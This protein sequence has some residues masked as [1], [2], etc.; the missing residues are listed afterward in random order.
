MIHDSFL[1]VKK[2]NSCGMIPLVRKGVVVAVWD[3]SKSKSRLE[4]T[5]RSKRLCVGDPC[6][7]VRSG[8]PWDQNFSKER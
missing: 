1:L 7:V 6:D 2:R 5:D 3:F 4:S 8:V